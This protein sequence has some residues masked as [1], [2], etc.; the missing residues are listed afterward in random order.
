MDSLIRES[1]HSAVSDLGLS[2]LPMPHRKDARLIILCDF[3][4]VVLV[5]SEGSNKP[6]PTQGLNQ[7]PASGTTC[8]Y[9]IWK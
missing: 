8:I 3:G 7:N 9:K 5:C 1:P 2:C 6:A 4:A